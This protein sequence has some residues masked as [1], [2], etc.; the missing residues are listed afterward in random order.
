MLMSIQ[1]NDPGDEND[2]L[3]EKVCEHEGH[4]LW[5]RSFNADNQQEYFRGK[6]L[7]VAERFDNRYAAYKNI[8]NYLIDSYRFHRR[9]KE[10]DIKDSMNEAYRDAFVYLEKLNNNYS[11]T[12][13]QM[14]D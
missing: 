6:V 1:D 9:M 5:I 13:R 3:L 11:L 2:S 8:Q 10:L 7:K 14:E 4:K 12:T